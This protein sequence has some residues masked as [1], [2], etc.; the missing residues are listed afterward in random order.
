MTDAGRTHKP[1]SFYLPAM[2]LDRMRGAV[3][4]VTYFDVEGEPDTLAA[5]AER[6]IEAEVRRL[7]DLYNGGV[8]FRVPRRLKSG[9]GKGAA[10]RIAEARTRR[11]P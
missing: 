8:P 5:L 1:R 11:E 2:L 4:Y 3:G 7:E 10:E 9:P 6:G